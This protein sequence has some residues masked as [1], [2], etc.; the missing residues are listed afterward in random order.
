LNKADSSLSQ[1][2]LRTRAPELWNNTDT[3]YDRA[4][5]NGNSKRLFVCRHCSENPYTTPVST[6][7][8]RHLSSDHSIN[9]KEAP[10]ALQETVYAQLKGLLQDEDG[11]AI[12]AR[13]EM[14]EKFLDEGAVLK[15]LINLIIANNLLARIIT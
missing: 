6:N 4:P 13:K 11:I 8:R 3:G 9:A 12:E 5:R 7:F 15:A 1:E 10:S 2:H 14:M